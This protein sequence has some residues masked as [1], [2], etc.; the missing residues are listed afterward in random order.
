MFRSKKMMEACRQLPCMHCGANDGTVVGAHRNM[1]K[2]MA[3]KVSDA[4]VASLCY[5][6][7]HEYDNGVNLNRE[8]KREM[9]D[10]AYIN[11]MQY[12]IENKILKL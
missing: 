4:L 1:G 10:K 6:C 5:N 3:L 9:W 11:T 8:Q 7:H 2:G 12:M